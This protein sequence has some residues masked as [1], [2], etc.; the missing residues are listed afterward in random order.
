MRI[1]ILILGS[2]GLRKA[3]IVPAYLTKVLILQGLRD[4]S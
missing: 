2:K 3:E 4:I 1:Q